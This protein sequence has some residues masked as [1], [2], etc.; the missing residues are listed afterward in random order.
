MAGHST[1]LSL[2]GISLSRFTFIIWRICCDVVQP[3]CCGLPLFLVLD[4]VLRITSFWENGTVHK[5]NKIPDNVCGWRTLGRFHAEHHLVPCRRP[6]S[7]DDARTTTPR[8]ILMP[9]VM[10]MMKSALRTQ[11]KSLR[12]SSLFDDS[13]CLRRG[14]WK[15]SADRLGSCSEWLRPPLQS[16]SCVGLVVVGR[17]AA[18]CHSFRCSCWRCSYASATLLLRQ[19][20]PFPAGFLVPSFS[21]WFHSCG[22]RAST[23]PNVATCYL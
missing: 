8:L 21:A 23:P 9:T 4:K 5:H 1:L 19:I 17:A 6:E 22:H 18:G 15:R 3:R 2:T 11:R 13:L 7:V 12:I 20:S 16:V 10:M 14:L